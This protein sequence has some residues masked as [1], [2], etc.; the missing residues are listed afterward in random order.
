M[1]AYRYANAS[2]LR[3]HLAWYRERGYPYVA[4][5]EKAIEDRQRDTRTAGKGGAEANGAQPLGGPDEGRGFD[6]LQDQDDQGDGAP[7]L[8]GAEEALPDRGRG[9]GLAGLED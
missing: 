5:L 8:V 6:L 2:E 3:R 4:Q 1:R 9:G 7:S